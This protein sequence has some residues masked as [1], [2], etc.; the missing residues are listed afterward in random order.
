[1]TMLV[2]AGCLSPLL[3]SLL[4]ACV[5]GRRTV[6]VAGSRGAGKTTLLGSMMLEFPLSQRIVLIEDTYL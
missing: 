5:I 4:W 3:A 1:M 6:L 2:A